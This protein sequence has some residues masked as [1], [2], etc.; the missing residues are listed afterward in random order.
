MDANAQTTLNDRFLANL[1]YL[2]VTL[3]HFDFD[4]VSFTRPDSLYAAR[5]RHSISPTSFV[6]RRPVHI[7]LGKVT[8]GL[9]SSH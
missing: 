4:Q 3:I 2:V 5:A 7:Q 1:D 9:A 8:E 6:H